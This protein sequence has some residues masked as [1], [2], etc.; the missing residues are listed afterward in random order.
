MKNV[1]IRTISGTL[2]LIIM[3]LGILLHPIGFV[4]LQALIVVIM[5]VEF[6]R[7][8][9]GGNNLIQQVV[10]IATGLGLLLLTA[11]AIHAYVLLPL[12]LLIFLIQLY[13]KDNQPYTIVAQSMLAVV[14]IALPIALWSYLVYPST[15]ITS[16]ITF[17]GHILLGCFIIL[18]SCDVGAYIFGVLFGRN[19]KYKLFPSLSPH[20]SWAGFVG[21]FITAVSAGYLM[22]LYIFPLNPYHSISILHAIIL[23]IVICLFGTWGD[24][25]ESQL[26]RSL[27]VKDSGKIMPGHGGLLDRFDAAL[28]AIP[29]ALFY[30]K[31]VNIL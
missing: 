5:M 1:L 2:F 13:K 8:I 21:G 10:A 6:F 20:K 14:Y 29:M 23:S 9:W 7:L 11:G 17:D 26:K 15:S 30:L 24:L 27:G 4:L 28:L 12:P 31:I 22:Y 18:W 3:M 16:E 25:V 19:S